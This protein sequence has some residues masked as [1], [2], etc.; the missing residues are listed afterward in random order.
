MPKKKPDGRKLRSPEN[1]ELVCREIASGASLVDVLDKNPQLGR[2]THFLD[3]MREDEGA[4][5]KYA[6]ARQE[7]AHWYADRVARLALQTPERLV[8]EGGSGGVDSGE[9]AHRRLAIDSLKWLAAKR[10]PKVYGDTEDKSTTVNVGVAVAVMPE[11]RRARIMELR[12]EAALPDAE[13]D[14]LL[15]KESEAR[16]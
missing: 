13:I 9:V 14:P 8:A 1:L 6:R 3:W 10:A 11:E 2:Y 7:Q 4:A 5:V 16:T 15:P 12:R